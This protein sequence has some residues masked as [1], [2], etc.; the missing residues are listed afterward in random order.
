MKIDHL[1]P[2]DYSKSIDYY[3]KIKTGG[4]I[5]EWDIKNLDLFFGMQSYP[6][7]FKKTC[8]KRKNLE[9]EID[10]Q[11]KRGLMKSYLEYKEKVD[12]SVQNNY[13][14][15]CQVWKL[16][17]KS[18]TISNRIKAHQKKV[19]KDDWL[20]LTGNKSPQIELPKSKNISETNQTES[21][22]QFMEPPEPK[23]EIKLQKE[24]FPKP[25][26][27]YLKTNKI[28]NK[29]KKLDQFQIIEKVKQVLNEELNSKNM[30]Q[31]VPV[32]RDLPKQFFKSD[33]FPSQFSSTHNYNIHKNPEN[34]IAELMGNKCLTP[35]PKK[36]KRN[37]I[38]NHN[39]T[40]FF[41]QFNKNMFPNEM[42]STNP[43]KK[44]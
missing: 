1:D 16:Q 12:K 27:N 38:N 14:L 5:S 32:G 39:V 9:P 34:L 31:S 15:Q 4:K 36:N 25:I 26:K 18:K 22:N 44:S 43:K 33:D 35:I 41:H 37:K 21:Q 11:A 8:S 40:N 13:Q 2:E 28:K 24:E 19:W 23:S 17:A 6:Y 10:P 7:L 30:R 3:F 42:I 20:V 29:E